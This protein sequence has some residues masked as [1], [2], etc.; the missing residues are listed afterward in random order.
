MRVYPLPWN[1]DQICR[2]KR[3]AQINPKPQYQRTHL[4][5]W[6]LAKKQ[7]LIDTI[8]RQYDIPKVYLRK[9][10]DSLFEHEVVDGQQRLRA[11]WEFFDG[12][13][14]LG[15]VSSD[16]PGDLA[17]KHYSELG[18]DIQDTFGAF[19]LSVFEIQDA[20]DSEIRDLFLRL[21]EGTSLN[22]A[23]K[24][25]AMMGNLRDFIAGVAG[26]G[27]PPHA[28]FGLTR[29]PPTRNAW[30]D[31]AAHV[32]R[33]ELEGGPADIKAENLRKMYETLTGFDPN[34]KTAKKFVRVLN[35]MARVLKENPPEMDIKWG[36][37]DLYLAISVMEGAYALSGRESDVATAFVSFETERREA[38]AEDITELL[39]PG[40]DDWD[41]DLYDYIQ[42]F[43]REG[44]KRKNVE[45]RH[46]VYIRRLLRDV[47]PEAKDPKRAFTRGER[48]VLYRLAGGQCQECGKDIDF[49]EAHADHIKPHA[50]G[51]VTAI[52]NGQCLCAEHNLAK[53]KKQ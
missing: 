3:R 11:I 39:E 12:K 42:A 16:L 17:N 40:H 14:P 37:V 25:N 19:G 49:S 6:T 38:I 10:D 48:I 2:S 46:E 31:L 8:L 4:G 20:A 52:S 36:F 33:L 41:R 51:G 23:E 7:L 5:V 13:Y 32:L 53:G 27:K 34:G 30:D 29:I 24:R 15:P 22:P 21:Q 18:S 43:Q 35:Y 47:S 26:E 45:I 9:I 50:L 44:N 1:V 28:V